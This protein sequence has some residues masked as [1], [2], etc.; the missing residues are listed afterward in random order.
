MSTQIQVT[1]RV[2]ARA[3][4]HVLRQP[5]EI[6]ITDA[7]IKRGY[8]DINAGSVLEI[9]NNSRAGVNMT[10]ETR[11]LSFK[12]AMVNG[13]GREVAL[14]PNGGIITHK[15]IGTSVVALSYRFVFDESSQAGT[16][17]WPLSV[18]VNPIE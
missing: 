4:L 16:Y 15:S 6:V 8:L 13:L 3:S 1:A 14:G 11:G 18:S 9:K 5:A 10:F 12:E 2:L 17:A 7:D